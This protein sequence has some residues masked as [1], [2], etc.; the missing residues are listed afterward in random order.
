MSKICQ[1]KQNKVVKAFEDVLSDGWS[2]ND[3]NYLLRE[4]GKDCSCGEKEEVKEC[5][6]VV[7]RKCKCYVQKQSQSPCEHE[8][9]E[10]CTT[11]IKL[12]CVDLSLWCCEKCGLVT[13]KN[14][15]NTP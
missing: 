10:V 6:C 3:V 1:C 13:C 4:L 15:N 9:R 7:S 5:G 8:Y 2:Y 14:P 12:G 11:N